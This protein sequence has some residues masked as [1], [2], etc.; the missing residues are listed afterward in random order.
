MKA[1][2]ANGLRS[3]VALALLSGA[4]RSCAQSPQGAPPAPATSPAIDTSAGNNA[5]VTAVRIVTEDG[6]VLS[7][8][9]AGLAI[10]TGKP[11]DRAQVADSLRTLYRTG[12]YANLRVVAAPA[13]GGMR[14]DFVVREQMFFNQ[15]LIRGLIAPPTEASAVA[16]MQLSLGQPYR[17]DAVDE[18]LARLRDALHDEGLYA[19]EISAETVLH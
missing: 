7:E 6:K 3:L 14:V 4:G 1:S 17:R 18:G 2:R 19:A 5:V 9:P 10:Q 8:A 12:N 13:E 11:L 16:A 15:V